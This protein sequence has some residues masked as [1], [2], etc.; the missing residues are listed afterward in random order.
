MRLDDA[1][2]RQSDTGCRKK[3]DEEMRNKTLRLRIMGD[4]TRHTEE[5]LP[6]LPADGKHCARLYDE[7]EDLALFIVK[8]EQTA[9]DDEMTRARDRQEFGESLNDSQYQRFQ[10]KCGIHAARILREPRL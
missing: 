7:F 4:A 5:P 10:C 9:G 2:Q 6:V 8:V 3:G 1:A